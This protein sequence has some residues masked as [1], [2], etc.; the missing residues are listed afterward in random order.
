[1]NSDEMT[2]GSPHKTQQ[3]STAQ[4]L[5]RGLKMGFPILLGYIPVG[6]AFGILAVQ[7][8]FTVLQAVLCS[9]TAIAGAGQFIA[10][11]SLAAGASAATVIIATSIVNLRY[12]LFA[13]TLSPYMRRMPLRWQFWLGFTLTDESFAVNIADLKDGKGTHLSMAGV[14]AIAWVGWVSGTLV[15]ALFSTSI[16]DPSRWGVD[17]AMPAMFAALFVALADSRR[18][19]AIGILAAGIVITMAWV[20]SAGLTV[21]PSWFVIVASLAA[22]SIAVVIFREQDE[23]ATEVSDTS[24]ADELERVAAHDEMLLTATGVD[25]PGMGAALESAEGDRS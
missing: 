14:G 6:L 22:A 17:F 25:A 3:T 7:Q 5:L 18:Q 13:T 9:A 12:V 23:V 8:G 15:G 20:S 16:G 10:V 24:Q 2:V 11:A 4:E 19:V 1:M 21:D